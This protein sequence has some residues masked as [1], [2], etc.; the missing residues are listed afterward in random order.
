MKKFKKV[1]IIFV[2][3]LLP[4]TFT[5]CKKESISKPTINVYNAGE[6]IEPQILKD[7]EEET[8]IKVVYDT[9]ASN[10]DLYIKIA[11]G[12]TP[13]DV[14]VPSDY[15]IE[16]LIK[17]GRL[18]KLDYSKIPNFENVL[19]EYRH[20]QFDPDD[21][22]TAPYF[23]GT[24]GIVYNKTMVKSPLTSWRDLWN[25]EYAG[26]IIMYNSQ[27]DSIAIALKMLGYSMN[28]V[29][30]NELKEA[31]QALIE[32]KSLVY[33]Y[34]TD[35]GR[36]VMVQGDAAMMPMYS[37]DAAYMMSENSDLDYVIPKEGTNIWMDSMCIPKD[38][39]NVEGAHEFINYLLRED[40]GVL[41]A[42]YSMGYT[43]PIRGVKEN[44]PEE[45]KNSKVAYPDVNELPPL[46]Y[47][48]DLGENS[49]LYDR[50]WTEV[51]ATFVD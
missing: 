10:E 32:Q 47:F 3:L 42:E 23:S 14:I 29:D 4:F 19:P 39:N 50:I 41:N 6:Y 11:S 21:Q 49:K 9:F 33:A 38:A 12:H 18:Q 16:R 1:I 2:L 13:Y 37:G 22:Y 36:D 44:L 30:P 43:S 7:F 48:E 45:L 40:V 28:S 46:E 5:S 25:K 17:E 15:M 24:I 27:R 8:G 31:K 35:D 34:L 51:S 26:K 20:P